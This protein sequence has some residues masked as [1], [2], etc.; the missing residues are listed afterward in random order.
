MDYSGLD[1]LW[2][3]AG[4]F[5]AVHSPESP[6]QPSFYEKWRRLWDENPAMKGVDQPW[7]IGWVLEDHG[8]IVG[9]VLNIP[10]RYKLG[11]RTLT[12][13]V[14]SGWYV[15]EGF[16]SHSLSLMRRYLGQPNVDLLPTTTAS[17]K[18]KR[19]LEAYGKPTFVAPPG[20]QYRHYLVL[21]YRH[22]P[23]R[24]LRKLKIPHVKGP[25]HLGLASLYRIRDS[26]LSRGRFGLKIAPE[27]KVT[28]ETVVDDRFDTFWRD[29]IEQYPNR[30]LAFRDTET[31]R[32]RL[33]SKLSSGDAHLYLLHRD[34]DIR[35][36]AIT[37]FDPKSRLISLTDLQL[38]DE[39]A[40]A[41]TSLLASIAKDAMEHGINSIEITGLSL[42]KQKLLA[43]LGL[44]RVT[45]GFSHFYYGSRLPELQEHFADPGTWDPSLIEGDLP[46]RYL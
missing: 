17:S 1:A 26:V 29:L 5:T 16:R 37:H 33:G 41:V 36:F 9:A 39:T 21:N 14:A 31:L 19:I 12:A 24:P 38:L 23:A 44:Y 22:H 25:C 28:S 11:K 35:G 7:P 2:R 8:T 10:D 3:Q 45:R 43:D 6:N 40:S 20:A 34:E 32:W 15:D 18:T 46:L 4:I 30:L 13:A 27:W 42:E